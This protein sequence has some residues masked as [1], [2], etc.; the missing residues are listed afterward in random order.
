MAA[1]SCSSQSSHTSASSLPE[2]ALQRN[3]HSQKLVADVEQWATVSSI[4]GPVHSWRLG[5]SLGVDLLVQSSIC[6]FNCVYC[7]LGDIQVKTAERAIY[8]PTDKVERDLRLSDW[9]KADI[10][11]FSGNGEPTLALNI[12]EVHDAIKSY[13]NKP[14]MLLT[15]STLL[16]QPQVRA[17]IAK[18]DHIACKLDASNDTILQRM[19]RPVQGVTHESIV[20]GIEALRQ[21][22]TGKLSLQCMFMP[23]NHEDVEALATLVQRIQP[24]EVQLN[25]P[26][27]PY[28]LSWIVENRGNHSDAIVESRTLRTISEPEADRIEALIRERLEVP[29]LSIYRR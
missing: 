28:P 1:S 19:N 8:I 17:D 20:A 29:V 25:T 15:N 7:Q 14:T 12:A 10:I 13:T 6:S 24:D 23:T 26:K 18:F 11:T 4:Y 21:D 9:E 2:D 16:H 22:Y 27:R 5:W 3:P